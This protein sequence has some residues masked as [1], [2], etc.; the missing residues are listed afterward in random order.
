MRGSSEDKQETF[1]HRAVCIFINFAKQN[2]RN[3]K[4]QL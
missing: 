2:R 3:I 1:N 4:K